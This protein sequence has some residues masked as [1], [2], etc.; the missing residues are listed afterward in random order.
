M[1][2]DV[3]ARP[4]TRRS[5][6]W[7]MICRAFDRL[8]LVDLRDPGAAVLEQD[9]R[10]AQPAADLPA[11]E[12][13]LFHE[14]IAARPDAIEVDLRAASRRGSSGT[15]RCC[16]SSSGRAAAGRRVDAR[17]HELPLEVELALDPAARDVARA[18]HD[19]VVVHAGEDGGDEPGRVAEVGVEV[20]EVVELVLDRRTA[21]PSRIAVP[22]PELAR[23]GGSRGCRAGSA[24]QLV[25]DLRR[26]RRASCRR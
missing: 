12:E 2:S 7:R 20:E 10:L 1:T 11:P 9:R 22:R 15:S 5:R 23:R 3:A 24:L 17:A 4:A 16:P 13:D 6:A 18:D 25:G 26:C 21:S 8:A 19:V 14:R